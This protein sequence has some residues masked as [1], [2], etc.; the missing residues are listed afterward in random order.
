M[1]TQNHFRV[2]DVAIPF[3]W[4]FVAPQQSC[5]KWTAVQMLCGGKSENFQRRRHSQMSEIAQPLPLAGEIN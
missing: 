3:L 4:I 1:V 2:A 5:K